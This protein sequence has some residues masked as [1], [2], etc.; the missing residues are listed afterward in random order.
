MTVDVEKAL[1]LPLRKSRGNSDSDIYKV[2]NAFQDINPGTRWKVD[3]CYESSTFMYSRH[4]VA[5]V[6]IKLMLIVYTISHIQ[7]YILAR[8][9][10]S[11]VTFHARTNSI[12][13]TMRSTFQNHLRGGLNLI[14]DRSAVMILLRLNTPR[15]QS[16]EFKYRI[17]QY[18]SD[19]YED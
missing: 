15:Y 14:K 8:L 9:R 4:K 5:M 7:Q 2:C 3:A 18:S 10:R 1:T 19:C 12:N 17:L 16:Q 6:R 13:G 11:M